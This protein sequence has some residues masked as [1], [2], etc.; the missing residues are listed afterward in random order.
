MSQWDP[1]GSK[2]LP[3]ATLRTNSESPI[4][5]CQYRTGPTAPVLSRLGLF[6]SPES[7]STCPESL[8]ISLRNPYPHRPGIP[9]HMPRN[10]Q[11]CTSAVSKFL[12]RNPNNQ[13]IYL[14]FLLTSALIQRIVSANFGE[15]KS[16]VFICT[17]RPRGLLLR[18]TSP[19]LGEPCRAELLAGRSSEL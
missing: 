18:R 16:A 7:L 17:A 9:I 6:T 3:F 12:L 1:I 13:I 11:G 10:T 2:Y 15:R 4:P 8:F 19:D 5:R 14:T